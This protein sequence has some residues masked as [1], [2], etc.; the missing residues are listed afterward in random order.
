MLFG[1][2]RLIHWSHCRVCVPNRFGFLH[3]IWG[4]QLQRLHQRAGENWA[5]DSGASV[6]QTPTRRV[7]H[8]QQLFSASY[9]DAQVFMML[10]T[11]DE[12]SAPRFHTADKAPFQHRKWHTMH[13]SV[14]APWLA[15]LPRQGL[16]W[17]NHVKR[18]L[19]HILW[20]YFV[21]INLQGPDFRMSVFLVLET[22]TQ[23]NS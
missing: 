20:Y 13:P 11:S 18:N 4:D 2:C 19:A 23:C 3:R 10:Q 14:P 6:A 1:L 8:K 15:D 17:W 16:L 12:D 9:K 22:V 5:M 7:M 21:F